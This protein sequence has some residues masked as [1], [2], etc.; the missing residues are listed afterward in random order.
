MA[1]SDS[2]TDP[3]V[4]A[5]ELAR[6]TDFYWVAEALIARRDEVLCR[7][8]EAAAAQPFHAGRR[9]LAVSDHIPWLFDALV[10]QLRRDAPRWVDPTAP[11]DDPAI[12]DA[13]QKHATTRAEQGLQPADIVAEFRLLRQEIWNALR[14]HLPDQI[15]TGD[16]VGAQVMLNDALDGAITVGLGELTARLEA[17]RE[18]FLATTVHEVRQPIT[19]IRGAA[20]LVRRMLSRDQVDRERSA[21]QL[22][23][24][25]RSVDRM[26]ALLTTLTDAS[27][28]ALGALDIQP[29]SCNLVAIVSSAVDQLDPAMASRV[30][31]DL[32]NGL[33]ATGHWDPNRLEQVISNLLSNAIKYSPADAPVELSVRGDV[34]AISLSVR[35]QGIGVAAAELPRLFQ[36]YG[37]ARGAIERGIDGLGLGLYLCRAI[38]V[39]HGGQIWAESA[40]EG[41]G[42]T[43]RMVLPRRAAVSDHQAR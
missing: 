27:R 19:L 4:R 7:W 26:A 29:V 1:G 16:V 43:V 31:L 13:A 34:V 9:E 35:D 33:D 41:Q 21:E 10:E 23:R 39:A 6:G 36:R 15:P 42:T 37:R 22:R 20:Q 40:G 25:E 17:V 2:Q 11:L 28:A 24:I 12:R 3:E 14:Q 38:V 8:L 18:D 32:P 30:L 5:E